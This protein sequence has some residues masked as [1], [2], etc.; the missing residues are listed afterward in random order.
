ML[1][2]FA[3]RDAS[4][5]CAAIKRKTYAGAVISKIMMPEEMSS[6]TRS[7]A[8]GI[9]LISTASIVKAAKP[10]QVRLLAVT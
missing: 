2:V 4:G 5:I 8:G 6:E 10:G 9:S 7:A 3:V 1:S